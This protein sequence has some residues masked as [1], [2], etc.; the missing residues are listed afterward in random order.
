M[1]CRQLRLINRHLQG[2]DG[3]LKNG[4]LVHSER[5]RERLTECQ[6]MADKLMA[7]ATTVDRAGLEGFQ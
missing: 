5:V 7:L 4:A 3:W 2:D 1:E 6:R